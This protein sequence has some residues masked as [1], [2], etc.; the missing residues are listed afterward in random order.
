MTSSLYYKPDL[1]NNPDFTSKR[2]QN[3]FAIVQSAQD[4][5]NSASLT[6]PNELLIHIFSFLDEKSLI[7]ARLSNKK[8]AIL[9]CNALLWTHLVNQ[10]PYRVLNSKNPQYQFAKYHDTIK[11]FFSFSI[12]EIKRLE[13]D[14]QGC[15]TGRYKMSACESAVC[16]PDKHSFRLISLHDGNEL[17]IE[18]RSAFRFYA[19]N[20]LYTLLDDTFELKKVRNPFEVI[21]IPIG[22]HR[23]IVHFSTDGDKAHLVFEDQSV[24]TIDPASRSYTPSKG[25]LT[26]GAFLGSDKVFNFDQNEISTAYYSMG[27]L[28]TPA[29]HKTEEGYLKILLAVRDILII[30]TYSPNHHR[31]VAG[32]HSYTPQTLLTYDLVTM[33]ASKSYAIPES[34]PIESRCFKKARLIN[35]VLFGLTYSGDLF[36]W[37]AISEFFLKQFHF[38][39]EPILDMEA[40]STKLLLRIR[41][42]EASRNDSFEVNP[43]TTKLALLDLS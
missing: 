19:G 9:G 6:L 32:F 14:A 18:Q 24:A 10:L 30:Q 35:G 4:L 21:S 17:E 31:T 33:K 28:T 7:R 34:V 25:T 11:R 2:L 5:Q 12:C 27:D 41:D 16:L 23:K 43:I 3:E 22:A 39:E 37:D 13:N 26:F 40:T 8:W 36:A 1:P 29:G 38:Y 42:N 15:F 20:F